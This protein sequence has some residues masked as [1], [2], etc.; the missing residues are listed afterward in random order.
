MLRRGTE[1]ELVRSIDDP[2]QGILGITGSVSV[3]PTGFPNRYGEDVRESWPLGNNSLAVNGSGTPRVF[4]VE[5]LPDFDIF[6]TELRIHGLANGVKFGKFLNLNSTLTNGILIE[7][8]T[9]DVLTDLLPIKSTDDLKARFA[10]LG[11]FQLDVQAGGDHVLATRNLG[12]FPFVLRATD[13]F[14]V[15]N[16]DFLTVTVRDGLAQIDELFFT[17]RGFLREP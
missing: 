11:G 6:V 15:G 16:D 7:I 13:T 9:D 4:F 1:T 14:G 17:V 3:L 10:S 8:K 2:R 12:V 5:T